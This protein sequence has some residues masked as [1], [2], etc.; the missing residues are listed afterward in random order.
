MFIGHYGPSLACKAWKPAIPLW[1]L[2]VAVQL[3]DIVWAFLVLLG[4]KK[5]RIVPGITATN[6]FD[7][8]YMPFTHS[9]PGATFW[10]V[11]AA[12]AY[13]A[14]APA[15]KW[16][17]AV[18][19][20]GAVFSHWILDLIVHRP[21]LALYDDAYK[22][23]FGLWNYPAIAFVLEI[24]LLFGGIVLYMRATAP[25]DAIGRYGMV[26]LGGIAVVLQAYVFFGPPPVSD[27]AFA[28]TALGLYFAFAVAVYWLEGRRR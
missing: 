13:R 23:G 16:T 20:G 27:T 21:D 25:V 12:V 7:L 14:M 24:A 15:Q 18:I 5:V 6:P 1:V 28:L 19:V 11:G 2:F 8:Y 9:L 17:A 4:I 26:I 10:S 3:V 22:V